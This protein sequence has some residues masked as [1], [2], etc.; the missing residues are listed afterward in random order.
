MRTH[1][2]RS[3]C[4]WHVITNC[5]CSA[6]ATR[7]PS[8]TTTDTVTV[9]VSRLSTAL[10]TAIQQATGDSTGYRNRSEERIRSGSCSLLNRG[11]QRSRE[12]AHIHSHRI[13]SSRGGS[14]SSHGQAPAIRNHVA[15]THRSVPVCAHIRIP[16]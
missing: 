2:N 9:N 16:Y 14:P 1:W 7:T 10:A 3:V 8:S 5:W 13:G 4:W 11:S 6:M 15:P 12:R